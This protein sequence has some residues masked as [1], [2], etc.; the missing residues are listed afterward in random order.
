MKCQ[1]CTDSKVASVWARD[2]LCN[3][4]KDTISKHNSST[5][6]QDA[7]RKIIGSKVGTS[8]SCCEVIDT[9][10]NEMVNNDDKKL[11]RTV[12]YAAYEEIPPVKINT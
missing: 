3:V 11:F 4:Q 8:S 6:H 2:G 1:I 9:G 7:E 12:L 5:K 10:C